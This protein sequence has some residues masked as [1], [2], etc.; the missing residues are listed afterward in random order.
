MCGFVGYVSTSHHAG[1]AQIAKDMADLI[2]H[3]GPDGEGFWAEG[4]VALGHRRLAILD[5]SEVSNQPMLSADGRYVLVFNGEIYN[6]RELR[7]S[8]QRRGHTFTTQGDSEV[9]LAAFQSDGVAAFLK[10]NGM[11]TCAIMD[12]KTGILT[13]AR[14]RFGVK[15]LYYTAQNGVFAFASEVKA[16]KGHPNIQLSLNPDGL[17]EYLTFMNFISDATLFKDV[18]LF[19]SGSY[20]QIDTKAAPV[21]GAHL[22]TTQYWDFEFTGNDP[23]YNAETDADRWA[24]QIHSA[25]ESAVHRQLVSDVGYSSFLSGGVDSGS[26]T[27]VAAK[28]AQSENRDLNTFTAYFDYEGASD[29]ELKSDERNDAKLMSDTFGTRHHECPIGPEDFERVAENLIYHLD[30]PRVGQSYPNYL[31]SHMV[32][33]HETVTLSGAGGDELFGG[34]P[35]RYYQGLPADNFNDYVDGYYAYWRRLAKTDAEL[36]LLMQPI[37]SEV[38]G[39]DGRAIFKSIYPQ[40]ANS[41]K[42]AEALLNWTLYFEAKTFLNGLLVVEDKVSMAHSLETRVPFLDND[43]VDLAC[44]VPIQAKLGDIAGNLHRRKLEKAGTPMLSDGRRDDG[45]VILRHMMKSLVPRKIYENKKQGFSAPDGT[46][47][48]RQ[49]YDFV[50]DRLL[51]PKRRIFDMIDADEVRAVVEGHH[52]GTRS[53]GRHKIWAFLHLADVIDNFGL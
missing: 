16:F 29:A 50:S 45:K 23:E 6:F 13:L 28:F 11:F 46:W 53:D 26:I 43:L 38:K 25:F 32:R 39:F 19:P 15:P 20:I 40:A 10:F 24:D 12:R 52:A 48:A 47:F 22:R 51:N 9:L 33:Q 49:S 44:R 17:A 31:V 37:S 35:W 21:A 3:R 5:L 1:D 42:T 4:P 30:E 8:L 36:A 14:D 7:A 34:Y 27:A 2:A 41:A 18:H